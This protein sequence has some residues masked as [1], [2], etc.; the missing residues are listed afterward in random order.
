MAKLKNS[1][2][3]CYTPSSE[4]FKKYIKIIKID[5]HDKYQAVIFYATC[6]YNPNSF[7]T[8]HTSNIIRNVGI[9]LEEQ[10]MSQ[11]RRTQFLLFY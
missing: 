8:L 5:C 4:L 6:P 1:N 9:R 10:T 7:L 3:E 2:S 11:L